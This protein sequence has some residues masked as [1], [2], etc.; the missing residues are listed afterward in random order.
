MRILADPADG[1]FHIQ[2]AV[3]DEAVDPRAVFNEVKINRSE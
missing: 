2:R 3:M 1:I